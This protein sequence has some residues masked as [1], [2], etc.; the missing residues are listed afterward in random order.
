MTGREEI[1]VSHFNPAWKRGD[2]F[3]V[4]EHGRDFLA[5]L[6]M[7]NC[8]A[9]FRVVAFTSTKEHGIRAV[10]VRLTRWQRLLW[11]IGILR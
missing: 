9:I 1:F 8:D 3:D 2:V 11:R 6:F 4:H 5:D 10:V 7:N